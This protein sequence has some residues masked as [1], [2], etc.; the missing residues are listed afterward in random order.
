MTTIT[1]LLPEDR[2]R[3]IDT[4]LQ[5]SAVSSETAGTTTQPA[6]TTPAQPSR[7]VVQLSGLALAKSLEMQGMTPDQIA[8]EL[9]IDV[10]TV[11]NWLGI[12]PQPAAL[13][14]FYSSSGQGL[15]APA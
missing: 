12:T 6:A 9:G 4:S 5:V 1:P 14:P 3:R 13:P 2:V 8:A 11:D 10:T 15:S 7:D